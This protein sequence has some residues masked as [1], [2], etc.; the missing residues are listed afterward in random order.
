MGNFTPSLN[1]GWGQYWTSVKVNTSKS[2]FSYS[3]WFAPRWNLEMGRSNTE[4]Y[5]L[6]DGSRYVRTEQSQKGSGFEAWHNG[7]TLNYNFLDPQKQTFNAS[8][9][10]NNNNY[11]NKYKG[12]LTD[13]RPGGIENN[14]YDRTK[15]HIF[16]SF[17]QP[18]LPK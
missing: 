13:E 16:A 15:I 6:A 4:R 12:I 1:R 3:G 17:A 9:N 8:L 2:E 7:H 14:M 18:L 11:K 5:E 10:F